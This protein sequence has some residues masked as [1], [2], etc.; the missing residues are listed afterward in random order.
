MHPTSSGNS[1]RA[2]QLA[3]IFRSSCTA[4]RS[5]VNGPRL[6]WSFEAAE[7]TDDS[8]T[9]YC[10]VEAAASELWCCLLVSKQ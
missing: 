7:L 8:E 1:L 10:R 3:I 9:S 6:H 5:S 2:L 4:E